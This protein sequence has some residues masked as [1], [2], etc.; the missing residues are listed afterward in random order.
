MTILNFFIIIAILIHFFKWITFAFLLIPL[1]L[2]NRRAKKYYK[3]RTK[4]TGQKVQQKKT[5]NHQS[6]FRRIKKDYIRYVLIQIGMLPFISFR[7]LL[8]RHVFKVELGSKAVIHYGAE[9]R[10]P[11]NL[12]IGEGS[13]I[14]DKAFLDA[15]NGLTIGNNVNLSSNVSIYTEQHDHRDSLFCCNSNQNF[16]V[17]IDDRVWL[18]PNVIVLPKV[19]IGEGAVVAAGAVVTKNIEPYGIYAGVPAKKIGERNHD[20]QYNLDGSDSFFL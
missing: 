7:H 1:S 13:I 9:I 6:F 3:K 19:H 14:G 16:R 10:A 15:R 5:H 8:Y 18:G 17:Q 4:E 12:K 2:S 11:F 20:L